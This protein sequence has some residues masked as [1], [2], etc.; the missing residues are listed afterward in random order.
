MDVHNNTGY[1]HPDRIDPGMP[2]KSGGETRGAAY[3]E[4]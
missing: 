4:G 2:V 3:E 1:D